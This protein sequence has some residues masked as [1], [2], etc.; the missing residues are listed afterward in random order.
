MSIIPVDESSA[1][2]EISALTLRARSACDPRNPNY[3]DRSDPEDYSE[4]CSEGV[5][6]SDTGNCGKCE[7]ETYKENIVTALP[8]FAN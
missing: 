3:R 6:G 2:E 1:C 7:N 4:T 5:R 8:E